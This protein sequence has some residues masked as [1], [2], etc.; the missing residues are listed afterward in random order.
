MARRL[1]LA[2]V[3][4]ALGLTG[5]KAQGGALYAETAEE[6]PA[7]FA[8]LTTAE[9]AAARREKAAP[10][11]V[12]KGR[13]SVVDKLG[14]RAQRFDGV[15][16]ITGVAE[17]F[18]RNCQGCH[19]ADGMGAPGAVPRFRH[20]VGYYTHLP[21]GREF[22]MRV[23]GV[24][25]APIDDAHLAAVLNWTLRTFSPDEIARDF[26]PFTAEEVGLYRNDP[27]LDVRAT[28]KRLIAELQATG[29]IRDG[30]DGL[31]AED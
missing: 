7:E 23:P 27:L 18:S 29:I 17:V 26:R 30:D 13:E 19:R 28:R 6:T 8:P 4:L 22:L 12:R 5:A 9:I 1:V 16:V 3:L 15:P 20:F 11:E 25:L 31:G 14:Q 24:A 2:L 10:S 21:E